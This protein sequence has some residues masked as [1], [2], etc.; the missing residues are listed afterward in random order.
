MKDF[1][2]EKFIE[3][4][5]FE[6]R[7]IVSDGYDRALEYIKKFLPEMEIHRYKSGSKAWTWIIPE[8]WA[9]RKAYIKGNGRGLLD[10]RDHPLHVMSYSA[11]VSGK[12]S[13][14]EL[15]SH[16]HSRPEY[17]DMIPFEFS[18]YKKD[19]GFCVKHRRLEEFIFDEYEVLVDSK[20]EPG[21]LKAG[22]FFIPGATDKEIVVMAHLCH[23]CM[24]DDGLSG[25]SVL[26]NVARQIMKKTDNRYSY[27]FLIIPE[28]IGT[29]AYL[30][31]NEHLI[32]KMEFGIF[33]EMLGHDGRLSLQNS[34]QGATLIDRAAKICL[35]EMGL[36]HRV[37]KFFE[38]IGNDE[39]ILNLPGVNVPTISI[40]RS[41]FWGRGE[42]PYPQYHASAD[43][44]EIIS[45]KRLK[46]IEGLVMRIL[47]VLE[48]NYYP[49]ATVKG[50]I[51]LSRYGLWVD[52]RENRELN[53]KQAEVFYY[54]HD[55]QKSL[56]DIAYELDIPFGILKEWLDGFFR[57]G[58]IK[59]LKV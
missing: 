1:D 14:K 57:N 10:L 11:S 35:E 27:R 20:F 52:W 23:P 2:Y 21:E 30:S 41:N 48:Q 50:P 16:L 3:N 53:L 15:F 9:V 34:R 26:I 32:D 54:L 19:W 18:Y 55:N 44:P 37:G 36:D 49:S 25:V 13:K 12:I 46:E 24:V 6:R 29:I 56:I 40:S 5:W 59:K 42:W 7:D 45:V 22:V 47:E 4:I 43:T 51:F 58:L 33:L 8:K 28:T 39:K 31:Q 17:H 38:V